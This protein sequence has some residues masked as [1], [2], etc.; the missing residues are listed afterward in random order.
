LDQ[1]E[2]STKLVFILKGVPKGM[3]EEIERNI[4]GY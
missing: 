2:D 3:E 4:E 1:Q